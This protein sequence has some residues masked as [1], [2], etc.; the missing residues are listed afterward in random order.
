[1][2]VAPA[3]FYFE[4]DW[5]LAVHNGS[6]RTIDEL[7]LPSTD[8]AGLGPNL[9]DTP[10]RSGGTFYRDHVECDDY[11]LVFTSLD[12]NPQTCATR[13]LLLCFKD[14]A[15]TITDEDFGRCAMR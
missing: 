10:L 6:S 12:P 3:C 2:V 11:D 5:S 8:S 1:L 14:S 13:E 15:I 4:E 7:Y 9:L